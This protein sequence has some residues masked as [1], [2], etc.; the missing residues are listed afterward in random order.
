VA[1]KQYTR[2]AQVKQPDEFI[3]FWQK[4]YE[5][6]L[7]Y[8]RPIAFAAVGAVVVLAAVWGIDYLL[9]TSREEATDAFDHANRVAEAELITDSSPAKPEDKLPR[10]KSGKERLEASLA[11]LDK[12]DKDKHSTQV[13][14]RAELARAGVLFDLGR[15]ADAE[16]AYK[17]FLEGAGENDPL[18]FLGREGVGLCL[19][20][21]GKLD[22]ALASF[23]DLE[24]KGGD[25]YR[26]RALYDQARVLVK[27]G[28]KKGAEAAYRDILA[29]VPKTNLKD[30][31]EAQLGN[32]G[33]SATPPAAAGG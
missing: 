19:E 9:T 16:A 14:K 13:A 20:A 32:L 17:K 2:K 8:T 21:Q 30:E 27:K 1:K 28:D 6:A 15:F 7:P 24:P 12:L 22:E 23:K 33:V 31:V 29:K 4:A 26:D 10:F 18:R 3:S 25:F 11:E 5:A